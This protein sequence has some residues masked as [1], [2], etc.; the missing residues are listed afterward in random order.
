MFDNFFLANQPKLEEHETSSLTYDLNEAETYEVL[1]S[2][3]D[4][5]SAG[6]EGLNK[7]FYVFFWEVIK[8]PLL[9]SFKHSLKTGSLSMDQK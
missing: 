8:T 6:T 4:N 2:F 3:Q 7:E 5:K 1:V 9:A